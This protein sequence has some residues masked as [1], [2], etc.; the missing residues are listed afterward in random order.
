V[1]L[2]ECGKETG[3]KQPVEILNQLSEIN[4]SKEAV[5]HGMK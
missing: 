2:C 1:G 4:L 5:F 3:F